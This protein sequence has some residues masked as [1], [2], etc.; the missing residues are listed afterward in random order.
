[1]RNYRGKH[2][3]PAAN[4][5]P[6]AVIFGV[7]A[8]G[9]AGDKRLASPLECQRIHHKDTQESRL[10]PGLLH[11]IKRNLATDQVSAM[12]AGVKWADVHPAGVKR[13]I[14]RL[15]T[16][17]TARRHSPAH[18]SATYSKRICRLERRYQGKTIATSARD[19][20]EPGQI[21][22]SRCGLRSGKR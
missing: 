14:L 19:P 6:P 15:A 18:Y 2:Y 17:F 5:A 8:A 3:H 11:W 7:V 22:V 4:R 13:Y 20:N 12:D 16:N 10:W 1:M 9:Q 21:M